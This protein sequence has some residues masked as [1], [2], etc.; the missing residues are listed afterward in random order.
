LQGYETAR[1]IK[2]LKN[3]LKLLSSKKSF[4]SLYTYDS[5]LVDYSNEDGEDTLESIKSSMNP[6]NKFPVN[7]KV[8]NNMV[9]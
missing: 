4:I 8:S 2:V 5:I 3:V 6:E 7:Y 9:F 1:N